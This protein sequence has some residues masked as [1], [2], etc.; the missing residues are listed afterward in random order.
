MPA[1]RQ[2]SVVGKRASVGIE[3]LILCLMSLVCNEYETTLTLSSS[4]RPVPLTTRLLANSLV[5]C[6][7]RPAIPT[8]ISVNIS[9]SRCQSLSL[10]DSSEV[11]CYPAFTQYSTAGRPPIRQVRTP[12][13]WHRK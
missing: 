6:P 4:A 3:R 13:D 5:F 9:K 2:V 12:V 8:T 11:H 7:Q 10:R 1:V